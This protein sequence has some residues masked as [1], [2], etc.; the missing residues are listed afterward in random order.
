MKIKKLAIASII[1]SVAMLVP[2]TAFADSSSSATPSNSGSNGTQSQI[3]TALASIRS[4]ISQQIKTEREADI[5][6]VKQIYADIKGGK[7]NSSTAYKDVI[8][9]LTNFKNT[10]TTDSVTIKNDVQTLNSKTGSDR[11]NYLETTLLPAMN[12][13]LN[14]LNTGNTNLNNVLTEAAGVASDV[15]AWTNFKSTAAPLIKTI[16]SNQTTVSGDFANAK[17]TIS[18]IV[19]F[20]KSNS[21]S[22]SQ[23]YS[24]LAPIITQLQG[25]VTTLHGI[26]NGSV[27][28]D[29]KIYQSDKANKNYTDALVQ[30]NNIVGIQNS[31]VTTLGNINSELAT[32]YNQLQTIASSSAVS[33]SSASSSSSASSASSNV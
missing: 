12:T 6:L 1:L 33:G 25:I 11:Y 18:E 30:L 8:N 29:F 23:N 9:A 24:Q 21:G 22:L 10:L 14:D 16:N 17:S 2:F 13:E 7:N 3:N 31:R 32:I 15:Q 28:A 5:T 20:I 19:S 26:Y 27:D 4:G